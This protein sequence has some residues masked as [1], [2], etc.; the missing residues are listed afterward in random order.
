[1]LEERFTWEKRSSVKVSWSKTYFMQRKVLTI[2]FYI[3][4]GE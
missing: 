1:M 3:K 4:G 2:P